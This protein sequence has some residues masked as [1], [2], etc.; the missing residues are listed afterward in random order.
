M[1]MRILLAAAFGWAGMV[2]L[3]FGQP[4]P[5][6]P[7]AAASERV[8]L[9]GAG[10]TFPAPLYRKWIDVYTKAN[11][12][13]AI[14]YQDV[15]SGEGIKLFLD[16]AVDFGAS[17]SALNDEQIQQAKAGAT[18]VPATAGVIVLAYNLPDVEGTL[19]LSRDVCA[20]I[21][22]G[23]IREWNDPRIQALNPGLKLPQQT[24]TLIARQD[25]SGTTYA[26]TNHL[27]AI[28]EAW[29]KGPGTGKIVN[30]PGVSMTAR[31]NEGVAGRIKRSWGSLGY[32]EYGFAK[33]LGLPVIHLQNKAG[34]FVEPGPNSGQAALASSVDQIPGNLRVFLP[35]PEGKD[36][37]PIVTFT[38]LLL[39][40]Q[41]PDQ[42]KA[43][44][45]KG[46]ANW[47]LTDGQRYSG[48]EGYIP[49]PADVA[50]LA[51][52]AVDRV[53]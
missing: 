32:V 36:S 51:R 35:D 39:Y 14:E 16:N 18:L 15:G 33:R 11:P 37:Y 20:D 24:I 1:A 7:S 29:R 28:S 41:Y 23:K 52:A 2:S 31:G 21:F 47:A 44:A 19:K 38:W 5:P 22:L 48:D 17:D 9:R 6:T 3:A 4:L 10:A 25:S 13:V 43:A 46:F 49:L 40:D 27:S 26:L 8:V 34:T 30:W 53:R 42:R 50:A 12:N 45:L